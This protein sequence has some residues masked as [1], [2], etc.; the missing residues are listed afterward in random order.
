MELCCLVIGIGTTG[1]SSCPFVYALSRKPNLGY[2][3]LVDAL[4]PLWSLDASPPHQGPR[5]QPLRVGF[6]VGKITLGQ[7][8]LKELPCFHDSRHSTSH[9]YSHTFILSYA[10]VRTCVC[11][12]VYACLYIYIY[13][14][15]YVCLMCGFVHG[16]AYEY[17]KYLCVCLLNVSRHSDYLKNRWKWGKVIKFLYLQCFQCCTFQFHV[18]YITSY[19]MNFP[20]V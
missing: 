16:R 20:F 12:C 1:D 3:R 18:H 6:A 4:L 17:V 14:Y 7:E 9:T 5:V 19:S 2:Y 13:I 11:V 15:I 8:F 10:C